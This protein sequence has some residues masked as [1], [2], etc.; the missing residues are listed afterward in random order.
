MIDMGNE[1]ADAYTLTAD[2]LWETIV[3]G[4]TAIFRTD[5]G[6]AIVGQTGDAIARIFDLKQ[7]S[8]S[9][10][11]GCFGS[12]AMFQALIEANDRAANFVERV[13]NHHGLPLSI[14]GTYRAEHP[15][16][17]SAHPFAREHAT[18]A[19]TIDLLMNA[20][21]IHDRLSNRALAEGKGVFGSSA[22]LSLSGSKYTF[23]AVEP[24]L[25]DAVDL[26]IDSGATRYTH[27]SGLGSTIIDLKSFRP[28]RIGI[29]FADIRVIA[30]ED[31][32]I[33]IP[34]EPIG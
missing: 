20:G 32:G 14:V 18:K 27:P 12:W 33:D 25:R 6:Y 19:G 34:A 24:E 23:E 10:P 22:N 7:R 16:I 9:K 3:D 17:T 28:F 21:P 13:V 30:A 29:A 5:V 2:A 1:K 31:C 4:G 26:A 15:I 11:C 8:F